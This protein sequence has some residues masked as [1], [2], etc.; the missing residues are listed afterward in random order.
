MM[1]ELIIALSVVFLGSTIGWATWVTKKLVMVHESQKYMNKNLFLIDWDK[2]PK[3][4]LNDIFR[5]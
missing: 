4:P 5:G 1:N 3:K 2:I